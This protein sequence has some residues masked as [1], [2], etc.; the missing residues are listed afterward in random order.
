MA[1]S[2]ALRLLAQTSVALLLV[3]SFSSQRQ[4]INTAFPHAKHDVT[5]YGESTWVTMAADELES[6]ARTLRRTCA[7]S[8]AMFHRNHPR[9]ASLTAQFGDGLPYRR[10]VTT[11]ILHSMVHRTPLHIF[12]APIIDSLWNKHAF[13]LSVLLAELAKPPAERLEWLFWVDGDTVVLDYC[14]S[15]ATFLPTVSSGASNTDKPQLNALVNKDMNGLNNG[16]FLLRVDE[17]SV[18][19]VANVIGFRH[20]RPDVELPHSEQSAM[21]LLMGEKKFKDAVRYV[22]QHWFNAYYEGRTENY[23]ERKSITEME[24][25]RVRRGDFLVHFPGLEDKESVIADWLNVSSRV[26]NAWQSGT[27]LRDLT[28]EIAAFWNDSGDII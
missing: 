24:E 14:Q 7:N 6:Q 4:G 2:R 21:E 1:S 9:I 13:I 3:L 23:L 20:Y 25:F 18:N 16:V 15:P 19:L 8:P 12:T 27:A 28:A 17:W 10:A 5:V 26:G 11:H 22:P